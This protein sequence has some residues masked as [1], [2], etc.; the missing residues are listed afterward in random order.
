MGA[1]RVTQGLLTSRTLSNLSAQTRR[2]LE[3]QDQISTGFR[4][5]RPSSDP[6]D[7]RRA[8]N[9]R[10]LIAQNEQFISNISDVTPFLAE[11]TAT[12]Q[13]VVD[14]IQR[15]RQLTIQGA[16]GTN[17][18]SQLDTIA[19]EVNELLESAV[20]AGNHTTSGRYIFGGTRTLSEVY[21]VTRVGGDI[22]TVTFNGN[23]DTIA[24]SVSQRADVRINES[25]VQAFDGAVSAFDTLIAVRDDL[26]AGNQTGLQTTQLG[27][28]D[29]ALEQVLVSEARIGAVENRLERVVNSTEDFLLQLRKL[30]SDKIDVDFAEA[31]INFNAQSNAFQAALGAAARIVQPSLLDFIR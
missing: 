3:L 6:I 16:N 8:V 19:L 9:T 25:G 2:I 17:S 13:Q 7:A 21:T 30:L 28:L 15:A 18:Q 23:T 11:T 14:I 24:V 10:T 31:M 1:I 27:N 12:L 29:L 20:E 22:A 5:T 4:V 26:L